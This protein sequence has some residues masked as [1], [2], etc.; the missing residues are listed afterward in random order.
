MG[1]REHKRQSEGVVMDAAKQ[2]EDFTVVSQVIA[3]LPIINNVIERLGL[4][5]LLAM[6]CLPLAGG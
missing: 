6:P 5:E 3:G 1:C 4:P 2:P